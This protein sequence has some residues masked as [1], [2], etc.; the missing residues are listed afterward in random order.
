[1]LTWVHWVKVD[2]KPSSAKVKRTVVE[3]TQWILH[4]EGHENG[5]QD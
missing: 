1:M 4:A 2:L 5:D 3:F